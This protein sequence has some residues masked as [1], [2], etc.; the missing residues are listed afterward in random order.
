LRVWK[1]SSNLDSGRDVSHVFVRLQG[2]TM[3]SLLAV[4]TVGDLAAAIGIVIL[5]VT[6][7]L[8]LACLVPLDA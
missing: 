4:K 8:I 3:Q 6:I 7:A 1:T 5:V 2:V